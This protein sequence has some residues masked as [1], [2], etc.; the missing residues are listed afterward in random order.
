[1]PS[2]PDSK[3]VNA[4]LAAIE[5]ATKSPR[6]LARERVAL[7]RAKRAEYDFESA[8]R[9]LKAIVYSGTMRFR[10]RS[11]LARLLWWR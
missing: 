5:R 4:A 8:P 1:M 2:A 7:Y 9:E 11:L 3:S 6:E 10:R